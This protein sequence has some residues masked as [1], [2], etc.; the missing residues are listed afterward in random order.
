MIVGY[1]LIPIAKRDNGEYRLAY[2]R[3]QVGALLSD[4]CV[5]ATIEGMGRDLG[6]AVFAFETDLRTAGLCAIIGPG[7]A[8][9]LIP[10]GPLVPLLQTADQVYLCSKMM[11]YLAAQDR[12]ARQYDAIRIS[13]ARPGRTHGNDS[14]GPDEGD[15]A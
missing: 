15:G 7:G 5:P 1:C 12:K 9:S 11:T 10:V 6:Y 13:D 14:S 4:L 8:P 2:N 3:S